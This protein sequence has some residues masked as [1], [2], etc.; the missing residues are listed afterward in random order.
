M[1][2]FSLLE[3]YDDVVHLQYMF[4]TGIIREDLICPSVALKSNV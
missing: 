1:L 4:I 3:V 2:H